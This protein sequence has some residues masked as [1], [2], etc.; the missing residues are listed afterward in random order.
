MWLIGVR[1]STHASALELSS[2]F[3]QSFDSRADLRVCGSSEPAARLVDDD[4]KMP[5][6]GSPIRLSGGA[7]AL[8]WAIVMPLWAVK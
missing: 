2:F 5:V 7:A 8:P 3:Q 4:E 1:C 6:A